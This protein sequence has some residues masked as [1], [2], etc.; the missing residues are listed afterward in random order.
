MPVGFKNATSGD[1]V[2]AANAIISSKHEQVF[3][4]VT[5]QGMVAIVR[6][7]GNDDCHLIHRGGSSGPNYDAESIGNSLKVL[8]SK[9]LTPSI[10]VDCSHGN[11]YKDYKKQPISCADVAEQVAKGQEAI[12]G[13][14]IESNLNEG[15]Q[16]LK[17]EEIENLKYGVSITDSCVNVETTR[18]MLKGL[19]DAVKERRK[20]KM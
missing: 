19:S 3:P 15:K 11:S 20:R 8:E 12:F 16:K 5:N 1:I 17:M 4:G 7:T 18:E 10:L 9:G 14:M 2:V 6:T 13:V